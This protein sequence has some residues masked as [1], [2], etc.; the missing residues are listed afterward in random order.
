MQPFILVRCDVFD[1]PRLLFMEGIGL[2]VSHGKCSISLGRKADSRDNPP[3]EG[4]RWFP[5]RGREQNTARARWVEEVNTLFSSFGWKIAPARCYRRCHV[6]LCCSSWQGVYRAVIYYVTGRFR[7]AIFMHVLLLLLLVC[8]VPALPRGVPMQLIVS[9]C[10]SGLE[11]PGGFG[12][13][14]TG[15][16]FLFASVLQLPIRAASASVLCG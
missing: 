16:L 12:C 3:L 1:E 7:F 15:S 11:G 14:I 2:L 6:Q 4:R 9:H 5:S 10:F 13:R 8:W